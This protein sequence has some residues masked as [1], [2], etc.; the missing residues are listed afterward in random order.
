LIINCAFGTLTTLEKSITGDNLSYVRSYY[1]RRQG[2]T[3]LAQ[4]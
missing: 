2:Y 4:E 3:L 1:G